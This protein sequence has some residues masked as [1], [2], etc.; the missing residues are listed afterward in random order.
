M[1][2]PRTFNLATAPQR[3][4]SFRLQYGWFG[5]LTLFTCLLFASA[6]NRKAISEAG[7]SIGLSNQA[8]TTELSPAASAE[9]RLK[10][11]LAWLADDKRRGRGPHSPELDLAATFI[12]EHMSAHGMTGVQAAEPQ[13]QTFYP[14]TTWSFDDSSELILDTPDEKKLSLKLHTDFIPL[15]GSPATHF[16]GNLVFL[17][18]G[19]QSN[20]LEFDEFKGID[21]RGKVAIILRHEPQLN[22]PNSSLDGK[23]LTRHGLITEKVRKAAAHG[24]NAVLLC[25]S[26]A[27]LDN[28]T[29]KGS[30]TEDALIRRK[31]EAKTDYPI[32]V[33]HVKRSW[34]DRWLQESNDLSLSE[35]ESKIDQTLSPASRPIEGFSAAG[36]AVIQ[37]QGRD[38]KNVIAYLPGQGNLANEYLVL[39]A[40][41]DHLGMG[42]FG[43]LAP[44]TIAIHNGADDNASGTAS[45]L[46]IGYR[47]A[48]KTAEHRR[49]ILLIAFSGEELGL[50][51]SDF[52]CRNP[53]VPLESTVA[54][55]NLDMV[56]RLSPHGRVEIFGMDT[57][58]EFREIVTP[59]AKSLNLKSE[60]HPEG[61]GPSDHASFYQHD[62]PVMHFFT[63]LHSDY[64]RPSDDT[65][66]IDLSGLAQICDLVE[67][68]TWELAT[69]PQRPTPNKS[70]TLW[71]HGLL[72]IANPNAAPVQG[73]GL[74]VNP[75]KSSPGLKITRINGPLPELMTLQIGDVLLTANSE[76]LKSVAQWN[77]FVQ[78]RS[79]EI[80]LTVQRGGIKLRLR[81]PPEPDTESP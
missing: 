77:E 21:L 31:I 55:L 70:Q 7:T 64:H 67:T 6:C 38:L 44:W 78:D 74:T 4:K 53:A 54:M 48:Q 73:L 75:L 65:D 46:E 28:A 59:I 63:G 81:I 79:R 9:E 22:D 36:Q 69:C 26:Q 30:E 15:S 68:I 49:G 39:G 50:L 3:S 72:G 19:I 13:F 11:S 34:V 80:V 43:S 1:P 41:Y 58:Q 32:P 52:Y 5:S 27:H 37:N 18:Y 76:E 8:E 12:S 29:T 2:H 61:Y 71:D 16:T 40:H 10:Q 20:E 23:K 25:S 57:A 47:L 51:G 24:A 14:K 42:Q 17:G 45:L 33:M 35:L 56:G 60:F 62:I 66:K